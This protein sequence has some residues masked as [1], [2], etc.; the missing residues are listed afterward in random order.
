VKRIQPVFLAVTIA[1]CLP[2]AFMVPLLAGCQTGTTGLLRPLST[3]SE[4]S[5]TNVVAIVGTT[6]GTLAP[7]PYG[8]AVEGAAAAVIGIVAAWQAFT[9]RR[10]AAVEAKTNGNTNQL[11]NS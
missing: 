9:H 2:V 6:A 8:T 5:I 3:T 1:A 10:L 7:A 11:H 4:H